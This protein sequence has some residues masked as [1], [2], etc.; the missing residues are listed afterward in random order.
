MGGRMA[1]RRRKIS[2]QVRLSEHVKPR[3]SI[4]LFIYLFKFFF[5]IVSLWL[6]RMLGLYRDR[7]SGMLPHSAPHRFTIDS[8][9]A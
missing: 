6:N 8:Y 9:G 1:C 7:G 2:S 4:Y 5:I 3:R